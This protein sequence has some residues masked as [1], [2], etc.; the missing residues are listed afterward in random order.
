M[1]TMDFGGF[2]CCLFTIR[3]VIL[4]VT[5]CTIMVTDSLSTSLRSSC[6][7]YS[8]AKRKTTLTIFPVLKIK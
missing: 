3:C 2:S 6:E 8:F 5:C 7:C 1:S 4:N